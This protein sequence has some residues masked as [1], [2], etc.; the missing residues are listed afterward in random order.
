MVKKIY[1]IL[2]LSLLLQ[3]GYAQL[4]SYCYENVNELFLLFFFFN[5]EISVV[6]LFNMANACRGE[7]E[8]P[9]SR[10]VVQVVWVHSQQMLEVV[11]LDAA[12]LPSTVR[13][14]G[15]WGEKHKTEAEILLKNLW[16]RQYSIRQ[17]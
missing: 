2:L 17:K 1:S 14:Q 4:C 5:L 9:D 15:T 7:L 13:H 12:G 10:A 11:A 16:I 3:K 8:G 6:R